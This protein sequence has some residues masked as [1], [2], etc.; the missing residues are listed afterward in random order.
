MA[1]NI[2]YFRGSV[3]SAH[4]LASIEATKALELVARTE[5]NTLSQEELDHAW[6][7]L[8][9]YREYLT[10]EE[11]LA[12]MATLG[13]DHTRWSVSQN[14][15]FGFYADNLSDRELITGLD[16]ANLARL[17]EGEIEAAIDAG[18]ML[19]LDNDHLQI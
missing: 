1:G 19:D 7:A 3:E 17:A 9:T 14:G 13:V 8:F 12:A 4:R 11:C 2:L 18:L 15:L 5:E 16:D 10:R 6:D